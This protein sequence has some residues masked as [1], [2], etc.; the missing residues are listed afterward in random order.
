M[1]LFILSADL[2]H[3]FIAGGKKDD[4]GEREQKG[5]GT[6]NAPLTENNAEIV[7]GPREEHLSRLEPTRC[8][9][10]AASFTF[11]EHWFPPMSMPL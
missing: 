6:R 8:V 3:T 11:I 2:S 4:G 5:D 9:R 7:G 1:A 10:I